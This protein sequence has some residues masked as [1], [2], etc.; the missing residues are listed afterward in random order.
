MA[1]PQEH[2]APGRPPDVSSV[3]VYQEENECISS[4]ECL[5]SSVNNPLESVRISTPESV[6]SNKRETLIVKSKTSRKRTRDTLS[7]GILPLV[8]TSNER[9]F[10]PFW[11][12]S[13]PVWSR[14]LWSC[15]ETDLRELEPIYW[16]LSSQKLAQNSW[17]TVRMLM[18]RTNMTLPM[19]SLPSPLSSLP[20]ITDVVLQKIVNDEKKKKVSPKRQKTT[21][22]E[23][24]LR[25]RKIRIF[26]NEVQLSILKQW[27]GAVRF[28]YNLLVANQSNVGQGGVKI[29]SL[30]QIVKDAHKTHPWLKNIPGEVKDVAVRDMDKARKAHFAKLKKRKKED[31]SARLDAKFKFRSK[32]DPQ[33]S[34]EVRARDMVRTEGMYPELNL[35]KLVGAEPIPSEVNHTVRFV[36][37]RLGRYFLIVPIDTP[38]KSE[39]QAPLHDENI[40]SLDPGVRTFQTTYDASGLATEWG[41]GDMS[42]IYTLCRRA[43]KLQGVWQ[44]KKGKKRRSPKRSWLRL[45]ERIKNKVKEIHCKM[46]K[47]LCE[48]YKV[49]LIPKFETSQ[50]VRRVKRKIHTT[51]ARN[52]LTWSHYGFRERL[53]TKAQ[54]YPW[55]KVIECDEPYTSKTCG[56]C[57]EINTKLGGAKTFKCSKCEYV[58]NRDVN[59]ARNILLRYLSL[60]VPGSSWTGLAST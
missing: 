52:M 27:F 53:K 25:S 15:I 51:T 20:P 7:S 1:S 19:T 45:L 44:A 36:R 32:K 39:N 4:T 37:D 29:A 24:L 55:V 58:A 23:I 11:N 40:V 34:F 21:E 30:R 10:K 9:G 49:I 6:A 35:T 56:Q 48:N 46:A 43:D 12:T 22:E 59:G 17:F 2:C 57:G 50:M 28:C 33:E 47:W 42:A 26:P 38:K 16:S 14:R 41:K 8:S 54:L 13:S 60:F 31:P 18:Q 5:V 3:Y